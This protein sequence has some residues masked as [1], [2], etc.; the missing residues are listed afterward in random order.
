MVIHSVT[1]HS[2]SPGCILQANRIVCKGGDL[3]NVSTSPFLG[4]AKSV[5]CSVP[6]LLIPDKTKKLSVAVCMFC[7]E[8]AFMH[9]SCH[10]SPWGLYR[11]WV[12]CHSFH[13]LFLS[14]VWDWQFGVVKFF[15]FCS[16]QCSSQ[17]VLVFNNSAS[18]FYYVILMHFHPWETS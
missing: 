17:A 4:F 11:R 15:S 13:V 9:L 2:S 8:Y 3:D 10:H 16:F 6:C 14:L 12:R 1:A 5:L 7:L 18:P